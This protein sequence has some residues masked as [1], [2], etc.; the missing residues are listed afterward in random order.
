M[1]I[2]GTSSV[3]VGVYWVTGVLLVL[4]AA[5]TAA[6]AVRKERQAERVRAVLL[7]PNRD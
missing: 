5:V 2:Y 3:W 6:T 4:A 1:Q 7:G